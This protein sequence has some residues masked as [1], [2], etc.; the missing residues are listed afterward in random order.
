MILCIQYVCPSMFYMHI[1]S[2]SSTRTGLTDLAVAG[3][4]SVTT[5]IL[6]EELAKL[7]F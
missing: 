4:S 2:F 7:I 3:A 6:K 5:Y 1:I